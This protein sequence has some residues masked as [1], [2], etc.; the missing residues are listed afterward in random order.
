[1]G[2]CRNL[3]YNCRLCTHLLNSKEF[4]LSYKIYC[5]GKK[6]YK[7]TINAPKRKVWST[8]WNDVTLPC[9]DFCFR[10]GLHVKTDWKKG[11]KA[12]FLTAKMKGW[13]LHCRKQANEFYVN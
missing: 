9:M 6:E 2:A 7:I 10:R 8:L 5:Y 1:M 11:S 13:F 12:F 4:H 3:P